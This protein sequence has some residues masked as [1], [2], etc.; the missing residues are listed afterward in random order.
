MLSQT[1]SLVSEPEADW[2]THALLCDVPDLSARLTNLDKEMR[3]DTAKAADSNTQVL[4]MHNAV[5]E[6]HDTTLAQ[7]HETA[8]ATAQR[9]ADLSEQHARHSSNTRDYLSRNQGVLES[10][11]QRLADLQAA[12]AHSSREATDLLDATHDVLDAHDTSIA[13]LHDMHDSHAEL[14]RGMT[15]KSQASQEYL[16]MAQ[17]ILESHD[18]SIRSLHEANRTNAK[19]LQQLTGAGADRHD[20]DALAHGHDNTMQYLKLNQDMVETMHDSI[21]SLQRSSRTHAKMFADMS[22][23]PDASLQNKLLA[24]QVEEHKIELSALQSANRGFRE[25]LH[26]VLDELDTLHGRPHIS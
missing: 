2:R 23:H 24:Q 12:H 15:N 22:S 8:M 13:S 26:Q 19:L 6:N 21:D 10:H 18:E 25:S 5:L 4:R 3:V 1:T 17:G 9:C 11:E 16:S 7:H 20:Y 14:L